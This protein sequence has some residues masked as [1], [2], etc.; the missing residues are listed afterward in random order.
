MRSRRRCISEI[1][2]CGRGKV[3]RQEREKE[4]ER[5]TEKEEE[6]IDEKRKM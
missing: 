2:G 1:D 6:K 4:K 3:Y 5:E